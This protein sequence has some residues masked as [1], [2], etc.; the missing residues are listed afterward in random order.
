MSR[1]QLCSLSF[2]S[3]MAFFCLS[4]L[5]FFFFVNSDTYIIKDILKN[6]R[7][8]AERWTVQSAPFTVLAE[9]RPRLPLPLSR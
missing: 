9:R 8:V 1:C 3:F 7:T 5:L 6:K 4:V 2:P